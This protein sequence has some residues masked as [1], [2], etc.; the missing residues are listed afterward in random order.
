MKI[1]IISLVIAIIIGSVWAY[2]SLSTKPAN[3][4]IQNKIK[5]LIVKYPSVKDDYN[6]A[7]SDNVLTTM[8]AK[9]I[10]NKAEALKNKK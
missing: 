6:S 3:E 1:K 5:E 2:Y 10:L 8:E 4:N 7:M 9:E